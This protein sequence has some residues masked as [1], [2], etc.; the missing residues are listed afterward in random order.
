[1]NNIIKKRKIRSLAFFY[2]VAAILL[3]SALFAESA[4]AEWSIDLSRRTQQMRKQELL[5]EPASVRAASGFGGEKIEGD[6]FDAVNESVSQKDEAG[7]FEKVFDAGEPTQDIV[8]LS[9]ERGFVPNTIR[10]RK[11]GRYMIHVVNVNEKE[12]NIS[13]ILDGF[14]ENH[15]TFFGRVKSFRLEPKKEGVYSFL[16][17]ETAIEGKFI[18]FSPGPSAPPAVRQPAQ[19]S[20]SSGGHDTAGTV[21]VSGGSVR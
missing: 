14:S 17:P 20:S 10:I 3:L 4:K 2:L 13:F 15:A 19:S 7:F 12:K 21:V 9:T 6:K 1:M 11:D 5:R 18:V 8:I 16:A